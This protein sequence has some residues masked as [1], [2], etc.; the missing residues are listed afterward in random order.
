MKQTKKSRD[1][2]CIYKPSQPRSHSLHKQ[3]RSFLLAAV[4]LPVVWFLAAAWWENLTSVFPVQVDVSRLYFTLFVFT[5]IL[6]CLW[7]TPFRIAGKLVILAALCTAAGLW[8]R[9]HTDAAANVINS[10]VNAYLSICRP[11]SAPYPVTEVSDTHLAV[12]AGL[13]LTPLLFIWTLSLH[14]HREKLPSLLLLLAPT[15]FALIIVRVPSELSCWLVI[16]SG[17]LFCAVYSCQSGHAALVNGITAACILAVVSGVSALASRPVESYKQPSDGFYAETRVFIHNEWITPI[18]DYVRQVQERHR[19]KDQPDGDKQPDNATADTSNHHEST[20]SQTNNDTASTDPA[21]H[22]STDSPAL[23]PYTLPGHD[24]ILPSDITVDIPEHAADAPLF[25]I[26]NT[27]MDNGNTEASENTENTGNTGNAGNTG[28]PADGFPDLN[29]LS[30][31][32]PDYGVRMTVALDKKPEGTFYYPALYGGTYAGERWHEIPAD[33]TIPE[34]CLQ[35]PEQ[36]SRLTNLCLTHA[37]GTLDEASDFIQKEFEENTVYDYEPG[38]TPSEQ[39]FAE[40]FLFENQKGFCVHFAT[41]AVLMY[42]IYGF[43]A[44]YVQGYAIPSSAFRRQEDGTYLAEATGEMGHA[45]CEVYD[46]SGWVLK[47]HTLPY[48][49]SRPESGT[50]AAAS[51]ERT[52]VPDAAGWLLLILKVLSRILLCFFIAA[53]LLL[54]QAALRRQRKYRYFQKKSNGE[55]IQN[56][57]RAIYDSAVFHG[58]Q[59]VDFLSREGFE[60]LQAYCPDLDADSME[61]LYRAVLETMFYRR[62]ITNEELRRGRQLYL[63]LSQSMKKDLT[64]CRR[65]IYTYIKI[66]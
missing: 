61:W 58:M 46:D 17:G 31:F 35:Y 21:D 2:I 33:D 63:Q 42:R 7:N 39:D 47:E 44:R 60:L 64:L 27:R 25:S 45:W 48:Y 28:S 54:V 6:T 65:F 30:R 56:I 37:P 15:A 23:A 9:M 34:E 49:G 66:L 12:M 53:M 8:I 26:D 36:L 59:K 50:P 51:G 62:E 38:P 40:Y 43:P 4:R 3:T 14:L 32:Q 20:A 57:Y 22:A 10:A 55:G 24:S 29:A 41:T 1:G 13:F 16:L 19:Q 52:W 18:Q 11:D 5:A